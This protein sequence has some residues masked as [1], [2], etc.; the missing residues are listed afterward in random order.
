MPIEHARTRT[1]KANT[2][3]RTGTRYV[4]GALSQ[5]PSIC[6]AMIVRDE[7]AVIERCIES[8]RD[9]VDTWVI[10]DTGSSDGTPDLVRRALDGIPGELHERPWV[11]FGHNRSELLE[12]AR[13][14]ADYLLLLDADMTAE[15]TGD[16]PAGA[17]QACLVRLPSPELDYRLPL[18]VDASLRWRSEGVTHEYLTTDD[19]HTSGPVD[20][21]LVHHHLD[22][23]TRADK[24][25]RDR[26]LLL[27]DW[28]RRP[29]ERTAFYLAQTYRDLGDW[30]AA[31]RWYDRRAGMGGFD[32]EVFYSRFQ[33]GVGRAE[34]GD[35]PAALSDLIAAWELR[36]ARLEP[37]Y[38]IVSRLRLREEY[39][40]AHALVQ[41]GLGKGPPADILF[42]YPWV[43]RWGLL[44]EYSITAYWVGELREA[45]DACER[46]LALDDLP[47]VYRKQTRENKNHTLRAMAAAEGRVRA[48]RG[49]GRASSSTAGPS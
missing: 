20:H 29:S 46:L 25:E 21:L 49:S 39:R 1:R 12:L 22:G 26:D 32:E 30:E 15:W 9:R 2:A 7:A 36:P 37:L 10:C 47:G 38:E 41:A 8:V 31:V 24:F 11:D 23:G 6:L 5:T 43:Y 13:G 19:Q 34:L 48:A 3:D 17:P 28:E 44:F 16:W 14:K 4:P 18:L 33:V 35:W 45:F 42:V 40:A 27:A